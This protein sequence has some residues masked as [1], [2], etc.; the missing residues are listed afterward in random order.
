MDWVKKGI[1]FTLFFTALILV[2]PIQ[3]TAQNLRKTEKEAIRNFDEGNFIKASKQFDMLYDADWNVK[4]TSTY[5]ASCYLEMDDPN[6][7]YEV[8]TQ[9]TDPDP[10]NQYLLILTNYNLEK[11]DEARS[12]IKNFQDTTGFNIQ[13]ISQKISKAQS[14]YDSNQGILIQNFGD[15]VNSE[16]LEYSAVMYND[17]NKLLFTSR[18]EESEITD[19]D[20]LA[21]ESIY[22]TQL[23]AFDNWEK[24][25]PFNIEVKQER[26]HDAT[27][28]VY[29]S[30]EKI[31][32]YHDGRLYSATL[33]NGMWSKDENLIL[34]DKKGTDTHCFITSDEKT[35]FFA[36]DYLSD[37]EHLDLFYT[38]LDNKGKWSEPKQLSKFNTDFDEDSPFL[39]NDST[40]YFSSNGKNSIGGYDVF[41]STYDRISKAWGPPENLGYP[42]NTVADDLYY[43]TEGKL[44]Y[45][46]SNRLGGYGSLDLYRVFLFN[47]VKVQGRLLDKNQQPITDAEIDV[48][49]DNSNIKSY[50][51]ANGDYELF[52]PI[53]K[54][55]H[56]TFIKDSLNMFE[57]DYI[58]NISFEDE[59]HNEFNFFIDYLNGDPTELDGQG[60]NKVVKH[61]NIDI[62]NDNQENQ[63]IASVPET[64]EKVWTDSMNIAARELKRAE[65]GRRE[66]SI[67]NEK[68]EE[69][70][71]ILSSNLKLRDATIRESNK[72][73]PRVNIDNQ[74]IQV[75]DF[76]KPTKST[77]TVQIL[78]MSRLEANNKYFDKVDLAPVKNKDG[79]DGLK[80]FFVGEYKSFEDA[81]RAMNLLRGSGY[82]DAF[83]RRL[84]R[85]SEL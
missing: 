51:D 78:A 50:T 55:M 38:Q 18:K 13:S 2:F 82:D 40:F 42:I 11:F 59:N 20:G 9:I 71:D 85:Y 79:K 29:E 28:Q 65:L 52:V 31:I 24:S 76:K 72:K 64:D 44:A 73:Q 25:K 58:A 56:V 47:R 16:D 15:E 32:L 48:K 34:H 22:Y 8:L 45:L 68:G 7:A 30:G 1:L 6:K 69:K 21:F 43:T 74:P 19:V 62:K 67:A 17:F 5:L 39:S 66:M 10:A 75:E 80:R 57:G 37:G 14:M 49:Y 41:K 84:D 60:D 81:K 33:K 35:I 26:S 27:V 70:A 54:K 12:L 4:M 83:I 61:L 53:N 36:S 63:I 23:D 46:S 3:V 77:Y